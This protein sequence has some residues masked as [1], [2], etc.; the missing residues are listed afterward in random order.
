[1]RR[2]T[3]RRPNYE[4][5]PCRMN[6]SS[7]MDVLPVRLMPGE[8]LR[9]ALQMQMAAR[10]CEAIFVISGIGSLS[11]ARLRFAGAH[12]FET[13]RRDIEI[14]SLAGTI[15]I[16]GSHL[17]MSIAD[18][19]GRVVGGHV[20]AGCLVRT[21]AEVL[22]ALLPDWKFSREADAR[23]GSAELAVSRRNADEA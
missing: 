12:G 8:D 11:V 7:A 22:L 20:G 19:A 2:V 5:G 17:H 23:T 9:A 4:I 15:A 10:S 16:D 13:I 18:A 14:L 1:M 6:S 3:L 21:T